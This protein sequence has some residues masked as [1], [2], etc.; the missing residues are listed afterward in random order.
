[1]IARTVIVTLF[2]M[3]AVAAASSAAGQEPG[4]TTRVIKRG[5]DRVISENT[6]LLDRPYRPLHVYGNTLRR[7]Y[8][9]GRAIPSI[10]DLR[11][12]AR[13]LARR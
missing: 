4:W 6:P 1:M 3:V 12:T 9:R 10:R 5:E 2:A 11:M 13:M 7:V 8:Y